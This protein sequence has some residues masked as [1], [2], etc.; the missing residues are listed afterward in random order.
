M[1]SNRPK[2]AIVPLNAFQTMTNATYRRTQP[3]VS[4][5]AS[6]S[7][8]QDPITNTTLFQLE[9]RNRQAEQI[10]QNYAK[11]HAG[12]DVGIGIVGLLPGAAIPA[13]IAGIAAQAPL[14]YK[15]MAKDLSAVYTVDPDGLKQSVDEIRHIV[16]TETFHTGALDVAAEFGSEF[17]MQIGHEIAM[18]AGLGVLGALC[19]PVLGGMVGAALDYL[20]AN[21][22][23]WRVGT[24]VSLYYQNNGAWLGSKPA[25]F[26]VAKQLT[27]GLST[28]V[29]EILDAK[30]RQRNVRVD[31]NSLRRIPEV[32]QA[33]VRSLKPVIVMMR[34][35]MSNKQIR[36]A[37][38]SQG[39]PLDIIEAAL[40]LV[41]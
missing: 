27:G 11:L 21:M 28:S 22:M 20:I 38:R 35:A 1:K 13:L 26:D 30:K 32:A 23:T 6:R 18:E 15:P 19:V 24:M 4:S 31:L 33:Q 39:V 9:A 16:Q 8:E 17:M 2:D 34:A 10:I 5:P 7:F 25:T 3:V 29:N 40:K 14:I 37:L 36:E 12:V 41:V